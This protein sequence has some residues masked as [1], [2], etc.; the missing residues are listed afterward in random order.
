MRA[1]VDGEKSSVT[2]IAALDAVRVPAA[3]EKRQA[4]NS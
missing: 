4:K 1:S 3:A 2:W